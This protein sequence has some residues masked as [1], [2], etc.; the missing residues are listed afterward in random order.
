MKSLKDNSIVKW[1]HTYADLLLKA[2]PILFLYQLF[3]LFVSGRVL[4]RINAKMFDA[5][6][7]FSV[8][9]NQVSH[10]LIW[11]ITV[12]SFNIIFLIFLYL[13]LKRLIIFIKNVFDEKPFEEENGKNLKFVGVMVIILAAI[14]HMAVIVSVQNSKITDLSWETQM[15]I[16]VTS[17]LSFAFSP[18]LF[19]GL[20]FIVIGEVIL[21]GVRMKQEID[22]TV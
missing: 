17:F 12:A 1:V 15:L 10:S 11:I 21:H 19:S 22:L 8:K 9:S 3:Q 4:K 14:S 16:S 18:Y 2:L 20:L 6:N 13:T 5:F 7:L